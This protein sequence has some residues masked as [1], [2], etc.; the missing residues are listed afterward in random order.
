MSRGT[1]P[2][3]GGAGFQEEERVAVD[4]FELRDLPGASWVED[5][6]AGTGQPK[7]SPFHILPSAR[8]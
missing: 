4:L 2:S 5:F 3:R 7:P 6:L 1:D 8:L